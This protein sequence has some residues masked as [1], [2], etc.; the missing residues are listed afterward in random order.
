MQLHKTKAKEH[1]RSTD[2][3]EG[4]DR[5]AYT[6]GGTVGIPRGR[7]WWAAMCQQSS[8]TIDEAG[9]QRRILADP[10]I[11]ESGKLL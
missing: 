10:E 2:A 6:E 8:M 3:T 11:G 4:N 5:R 1:S 9:P 7:S